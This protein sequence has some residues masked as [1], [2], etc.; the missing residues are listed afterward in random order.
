MDT[1]IA[2]RRARLPGLDALFGPKAIAFVGASTSKDKI[3]YH[4][5]KNLVEF[6]F[7]GSI[8]PIHP[9]ASEICGLKAYPTV[10]AI[11]H[12]VDRAFIAVGSNQVPGVLAECREKGVKVAQVLTAGFSEFSRDSAELERR[13]L[14]QVADGPMRMVGPNCI[15]TFSASAKMAIGAARYNP[16]EPGNITFFSQ[17]GTFAG[18]VVRRAQVWGLPLGRALSCG[19]SAGQRSPMCNTMAPVSNKV[20][21]SSS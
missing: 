20:R 7:T 6:G 4:L 8:Y 9:T 15:G 19:S 3:G 12:E 17:S 14:D 13:M 5:I 2:R 16:V 18:D 11:P 1:A 21:P 10:K